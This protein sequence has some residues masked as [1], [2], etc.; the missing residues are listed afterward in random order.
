M[1]VKIIFDKD[2]TYET[3]SFL[4]KLINFFLIPLLNNLPRHLVVGY[5]KEAEAVH[6]QATTHKALDIVYSFDHKLNF[7]KGIINGFL[8]YF[9]QLTNNAKALRNRF[10]LVK[11]ELKKAIYF[12]GKKEIKL[13]NLACGSSKAVIEVIAKYQDN[14]SFRAFGVDKSDLAIEDSRKLSSDFKINHFFSWHQDTISNFLEKHGNL[15]FDIIE[16]VGF[17]DYLEDEKAVSL[18]NQIYSVLSDG[19]VFITGNIKDNPER[20][21]LT[22]VIGWPHLIFRH[23][24]DLIKLFE[25]SQFKASEI[26]IIYEPQKIHSVVVCK[27]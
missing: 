27:K 4:R 20:K 18:F 26:K 17:L 14:F 19:G 22:E 16:M 3:N 9:W 23:E 10:K 1:S 8:T 21:F 5:S 2:S 12:L 15:K 7:E 11:K 6:K 13:L 24:S 25:A